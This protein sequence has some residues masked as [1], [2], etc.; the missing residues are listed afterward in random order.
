MAVQLRLVK[1][2]IP[3]EGWLG[4][5][6][7]FD[8]AGPEGLLLALQELL[9]HQHY[10]RLTRYRDVFLLEPRFTDLQEKRAASELMSL[11][12]RWEKLL[13][14]LVRL[15]VHEVH[16]VMVQG[17]FVKAGDGWE[18]IALWLSLRVQL[19]PHSFLDY[20]PL[21]LEQQMEALDYLLGESP[22]SDDAAI[23]DR[24]A[25]SDFTLP[26]D[27]YRLYDALRQKLG[28][29]ELIARG[30]LTK[31]EAQRVRRTLNYPGE[32][33]SGVPSRKIV[34]PGGKP[35]TEPMEWRE[36]VTIVRRVLALWLAS[37][38]RR[39]PEY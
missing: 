1:T 31:R 17:A 32:V 36:L 14:V 39:K 6:I 28:E 15:H 8:V 29:S 9:S 23:L 18:R 21:H 27:L 7:A 3:K 4:G 20:D 37:K 25:Q 2:L 38:C 16:S 34:P 12:F 22:D 30:Y 26:D 19:R 13:N 35:S 5:Q 33:Y 24:L 11:G 10:A